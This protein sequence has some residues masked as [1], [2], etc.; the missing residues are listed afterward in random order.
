MATRAAQEA[1]ILNPA[2]A[3]AFV[4]RHG[5]VCEAVRRGAVPS[6]AAAIAGETLRGNWWSHPRSRDIFA[7]TRAVRDAPEVLV[8]RLVD[9]KITFV[10]ER[11]WPALVRAGDRFAPE[12]LAR[13]RE[14]H[15][16]SGQHVLE[17][18]PFPE[19]VPRAVAA[20]AKRLSADA[21]REA[22]AAV[23]SLARE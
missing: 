9:G 12:R 2:A 1:R 18:T 4:A 8:C 10:H 21:A 22:L 16:A 11:L 17:Q 13:V 19:W 7:I 3:L 23:L 5:V 14:V 20:A 15:G 6:L